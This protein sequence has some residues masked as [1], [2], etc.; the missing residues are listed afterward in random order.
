MTGTDTIHA[1]DFAMK[2][3]SETAAGKLETRRR[4]LVGMAAG[5]G[6]AALGLA[7]PSASAAESPG[8]ER[9][10]AGYRETDHVREYY[11]TARI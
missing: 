10:P 11:R 4:F 1:E 9:R 8:G 6:A 2:R 3:D 7:T 5:G